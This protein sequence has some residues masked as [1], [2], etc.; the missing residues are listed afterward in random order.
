MKAHQNGHKENGSKKKD[1]LDVERAVG[2][3]MDTPPAT[4]NRAGDYRA[5]AAKLWSRLAGLLKERPAEVLG[6]LAA[7]SF[8]AGVL[9]GRSRRRS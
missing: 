6:A 8:F 7:V 3:G 9:F 5:R 2:E 4:V 1:Q